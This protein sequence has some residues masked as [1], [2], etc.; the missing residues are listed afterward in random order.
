MGLQTLDRAV[1]VL[2]A[3]GHAGEAGLRLVDL[4]QAAG[5]A[6]PTMHRLAT[7]LAAHGLVALD[8]ETRRYRLG[9]ELAIL[10]WSV[11]HREQDLRTAAM[12]SATVLADE[13]GDTVFVVVRSGL[14]SVCI[15]RH[16]G[17][18]P[19]KALT[20]EIGT[21]RALCVGA[22]GLAMLACLPEAEC[23]SILEAVAERA[24]TQSRATPAQIRAAIR[25]ARKSGYS[26]SENFVTE[27]V[28]AVSV[29]IRDYRGHPI[30]A[31]GVA[32]IQPRIPASRIAALAKSLERERRMIES[33]LLAVQAP[34]R[35]GKKA[36]GKARRP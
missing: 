8:P 9:H 15:E 7:A 31:I 24:K 19:I 4:Q 13:T 32:A 35:T 36:G 1:A 28:R 17:A 27:G 6:K 5:L 22:G 3:L 30:A 26:V 29:A 23:D 10:G 25:A 34:R 2:R 12:H 18:Y 21:R 11:A 16:T 20:V 33:R 14:D